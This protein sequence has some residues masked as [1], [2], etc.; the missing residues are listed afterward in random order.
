MQTNNRLDVTLGE[1]EKI[2]QN[3]LEELFENDL[4]LLQNDVS[5]RA[6]TYKLAEY[7][8]NQIPDLNVDCE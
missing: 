2:V 6:I 8:Q 1:I 3:C 5:E 7:L 4:V